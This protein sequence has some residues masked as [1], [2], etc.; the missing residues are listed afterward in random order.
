MKESTDEPMTVLCVIRHGDA[1]AHLALPQ[2]D[3]QRPLTDKGKRQSKRA[4]R[5]LAR[6]GLSPHEIWS[7][8]LVRAVET[9]ELAA[10][11]AESRAARIETADL[12]PDAAPARFVTALGERP[13]APRS[14]PRRGRTAEA[15]ATDVLW[16]VGHEP[17]L[18]LLIGYVTGA[19]PRAF[20]LG[21]G[22]VA[23]IEFPGRVV[24][25][26]AGRVTL[27]VAAGALKELD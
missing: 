3:R 23:V 20:L 21:K 25:A 10:K 11:G 4:G 8:K 17:H 6:L 22:A 2:R 16:V 24:A 7:S 14:K 15:A 18:S 27:F 9:A 19:P 5:V 12:A 26:G 13:A 1:G